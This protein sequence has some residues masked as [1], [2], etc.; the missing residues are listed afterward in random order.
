MAPE[1]TLLKIHSKAYLQMLASLGRIAKSKTGR[2]LSP[3]W[4]QKFAAQGNKKQ[5]QGADGGQGGSAEHEQASM[6]RFSAGSY[7]A[8]LSA[9]GAVC[10][11]VDAVLRGRHEA[12]F[13]NVR[14][15]GARESV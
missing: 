4:R 2:P 10:R 9:S 6:T 11:A 5:G 14:P 12:A 3:V 15:P 8:A 7:R 13:C 1:E